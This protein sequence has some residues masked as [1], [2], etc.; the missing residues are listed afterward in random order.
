MVFDP[1]QLDELER[2]FHEAVQK[3]WL[4]REEQQQ[5]QQAAGRVDAG[6]RGA[7]TGGKQMSAL[8]ELVV[9]IVEGAGLRHPTIETDPELAGFTIRTGSK[10][11]L[12]GY[13]RPEKRWDMLVLA[14]GQ[15]VAAIEFKSQVGSFGK[16]INNRAEEAIGSAEDIWKAYREGLFHDSPR[17]FLGYLFLLE[18]APEVHA[19][20]GNQEPHFEVD[21][22][23]K[24]ASYSKRYELLCRRLVLER[25]YTAAC[26]VLTSKS[27]LT[28]ITQPA[29]DLTFRRFAAA[30]VGHVQTFL[31]SQ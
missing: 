27:E 26:L 30:L 29:E 5:R 17:P 11:E 10:L 3:F 19:P 23:F 13:Y 24:R 21:P 18:D 6:T 4:T 28:S 9:N 14:R 12:P 7:V 22:E 2:R 25:L 15:L 20:I 8:E 31:L 1:S 16:N